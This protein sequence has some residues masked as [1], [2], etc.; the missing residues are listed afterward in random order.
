MFGRYPA[1]LT[2]YAVPA[3]SVLLGRAPAERAAPLAT[4]LVFLPA[5]REPDAARAEGL[6]RVPRG[7]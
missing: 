2:P 6:A 5:T 7:S 3:P 4:R 1:D